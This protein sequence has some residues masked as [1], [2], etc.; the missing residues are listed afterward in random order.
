MQCSHK[1][2]T[3]DAIFWH[4]IEQ[5]TFFF[6]CPYYFWLL[7][8]RVFLMFLS[9]FS[10]LSDAPGAKRIR[11][12]TPTIIPRNRNQPHLSVNLFP[13]NLIQGIQR[14]SF[15]KNRLREHFLGAR[16]QRHTAVQ[17]DLLG[18]RPPVSLNVSFCHPSSKSQGETLSCLKSVAKPPLTRITSRFHPRNV[19]ALRES[20]KQLQT[21]RCSFLKYRTRRHPAIRLSW[22]Y[23]YSFFLSLSKNY[24]MPAVRFNS[25]A[26]VK[27][28]C[29]KAQ[30]SGAMATVFS[31]L[32]LNF[33]GAMHKI[34]VHFLV[35]DL[36][37]GVKLGIAI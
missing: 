6:F 30:C 9:L 25:F 8:A 18:L 4:K 28:L 26:S 16:M 11:C 19:S 31:N 3:E 2:T 27:L 22:K 5:K 34:L 15:C 1:N 21:Q 7:F 12:T 29:M 17:P 35:F 10:L 37:V 24:T 32:I 14:S 13:L 23:P 33:Y 36:Q 20:L